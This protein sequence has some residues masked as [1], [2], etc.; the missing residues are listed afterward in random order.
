MIS[1][2]FAGKP[3]V[4]CLRFIPLSF[5]FGFCPFSLSALM[6]TFYTKALPLS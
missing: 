5:L 3:P 1:L 6:L 4:A 2:L